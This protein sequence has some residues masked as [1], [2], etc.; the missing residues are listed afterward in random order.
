MGIERR[1]ICISGQ[2]RQGKIGGV[3]KINE[4]GSDL[5]DLGMRFGELDLEG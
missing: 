5:R 3:R 4:D 2:D 1:N